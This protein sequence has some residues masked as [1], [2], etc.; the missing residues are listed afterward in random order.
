MTTPWSAHD[1]RAVAT[2]KISMSRAMASL[3]SMN[4]GVVDLKI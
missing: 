1:Q 4:N 3:C 2:T